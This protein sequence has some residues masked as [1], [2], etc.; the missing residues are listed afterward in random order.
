[1]QRR[2][3]VLALSATGWSAQVRAQAAASWPARP[4]RLIVPST[5]GSAADTLARALAERLAAQLGQPFVVENRPGAGGTTGT[6]LVARAEPDG[7]TLL[8]NSSSHTLA[9]STY[10]NLPYDTTGDLAAVTPLANLPNVLVVP[11][12]S[13]IRTAAD[14]VRTAR[15]KP[16]TLNY[17]TGG[18]GSPAH[19]NAER[20]RL[21]AG[22]AAV[23]VPFKGA[24]EALAEI[25]AGRV[26]FY[27]SPLLP[28]LPL[29]REGKLRAIAVGSSRRALALPEVPTTLEAGYANSD[30]N[31]WV[32][33][34]VPARTPAP[35][36]ARLH[37][38]TVKALDTPEARERWSR[39]G[40]EPMPMGTEQFDVYVGEEIEANAVLVKAAGIK[41]N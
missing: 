6:N 23:H 12:A 38:E 14:L 25:L 20:F 37:R 17:A 26:D 4:V 15:A 5:P 21:S 34:F 18:N 32:G 2:H 16:G 35:I 11:A 10:P 30:Y 36:V 39:L 31:A 27:F 28:A 13:P 3:F 41:A 19:L 22:F 9:P 1:M 8:V 24:P 40:A 33:M 29:L 7:Y